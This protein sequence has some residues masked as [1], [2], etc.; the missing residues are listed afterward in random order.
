MKK[1]DILFGRNGSG[2]IHPIV[3]LDEH[4]QNFFIGAMLTKSSNYTDN[5]LMAEKHFKKRDLNNKYEF[6]FNN[7]HLVNAQ[8]IKK[9]E[10]KPFRKVGELTNEGIEFIKSKI[11]DKEP[12]FWEDY[13]NKKT[14]R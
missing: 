3:Y 6:C 11:N 14:D 12:R 8:L 1:G 4:D 10:W 2:A 9:D 5:I 7:T 13:L